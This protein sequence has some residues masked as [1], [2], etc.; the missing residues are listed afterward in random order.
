MVAATLATH[1]VGG[2][3]GGT[4]ARGAS[5]AFLAGA[6][7]LAASL[8]HLGRPTRALKALRNLRTS[9]LSREVALF[10]AFS[11]ASFGYAAAWR[12]GWPSWV[13]GA[14]GLA[15]VVL[16]GA[17]VYA[18]GRLYLVPARPVW[19]S[20]R[21][22]VAFFATGL[23]LGPLVVLFRVDR[24]ALDPAWIA[25]V[26]GA[27]AVGTVGQLAVYVHLGRA[28]RRR[29]DRQHRGT[30][31]LLFERLGGLFRAR[32]ACATVG[33]V[34][35]ASALAVPLAGPAAAGRLEA[36]LVVL[37]GGELVGRYLFY[38]TVVPFGIAGSFF[39]RA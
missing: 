15:A 39:E 33:L 17:G 24:A 28:V 12:A 23:T 36:A 3:G 6:T 11:A 37:A 34:L 10:S 32:V 14:L 1:L 2:A 35:L 31:H 20:G 21:T 5:A 18:S 9:W 25:A 7:A 13:A 29:A 8:L 4:L 19:N 22:L 27:A 16:G 30:A 38:V 26:V